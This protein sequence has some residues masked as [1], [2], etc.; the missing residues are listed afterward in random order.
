[1]VFLEQHVVYPLGDRYS[2][3]FAAYDGRS[4]IYPLVMVDSGHQVT[5][6]YVVSFHETYKGMVDAELG[7]PALARID[8]YTERTGDTLRFDVELTNFSGVPLSALSNGATVHAIVYEDA[9]VGTTDRIVR[10]AVSTGITPELAH[11][12]MMTFTLETTLSGVDWN[13]IHPLV[14]ADYRPGGLTGAYD[15]LQATLAL[16]SPFSVRPDTLTFM[17]AP[18]DVADPAVNLQVEGISD[19]TWTALTS[20]PWLT[21]TPTSGTMDVAPTVSVITSALSSGWQQGQIEFTGSSDGEPR[22]DQEVPVRAYLGPVERVYL[23][24]SFRP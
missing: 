4:Y 17:V 19:L 13:K 10:A 24:L 18:E 12:A 23:P 7:R 14:L 20:T 6:G 1:M 5:D 11:G 2:R 8:A 22:F 3:W 21:V 9:H 15:M 16:A